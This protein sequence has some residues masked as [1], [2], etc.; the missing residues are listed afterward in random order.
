MGDYEFDVLKILQQYGLRGIVALLLVVSF[1]SLIRSEFVS[2]LWHRFLD[3]LIE[4]LM[5]RKIKSIKNLSL[6]ESDILNHDIFNYIDFWMYSKIPTFKFSTEYRTSIFKKYLTIYLKCYKKNILEYVRSGSYKTMDHS[7]LW[8]TFLDLINKIVY[9][10]ESQAR[11]EG[12][13]EVVIMKMK[14]K[15]NDAIILTM[16]I[17]ENISNSQFYESDNNYLKV[18]STLNILLSVLENII[19]NSEAVGKSINGELKEN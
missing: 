10:Y 4:V 2:R 14:E 11:E 13:P 5:S 15:N 6:T 7:A 1:S 16:D 12:I 17:I 19:S 18:Y 8:K 9:D 3:K